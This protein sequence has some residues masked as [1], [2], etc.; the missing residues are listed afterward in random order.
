VRSEPN[1]CHHGYITVR[2]GFEKRTELINEPS[3]SGLVAAD[4]H[5][6]FDKTLAIFEDRLQS[7]CEPD[8]YQ[9]LAIFPPCDDPSDVCVFFSNSGAA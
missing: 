7:L 5:E 3:Q 4:L 1:S 2:R 8:F 9:E 6:S